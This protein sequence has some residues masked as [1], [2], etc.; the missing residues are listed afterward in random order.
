[1]P[2][3]YLAQPQARRITT[4][5]GV[6]A[7]FAFV[8]ADATGYPTVL[9]VAIAHLGGAQY[10]ALGSAIGGILAVVSVPLLAFLAAR[11]PHT[12]PTL[13]GCGLLIQVAAVVVRGIA[14]NIWVLLGAG[15]F[16]SL[17]TAVSYVIGLPLVRDMFPAAR[18][19]LLLGLVGTASSIGQIAGPVSVGRIIDWW[20]WRQ[21]SWF[22]APLLAI[23]AVLVLAGA[24]I[25][26][27][28]GAQIAE[29]RRFDA[30]GAF[31]M[32]ALVTLLILPLSLGHSS[33][34]YGGLRSYLLF[35]G[36][37]LGVVGF[38]MVVR[39]KKESAFISSEVFKD[40]NTLALTIQTFLS[41]GSSFTVLAF[42]PLY[43]LY[44]MHGSGFQSG[45]A[46]A[47]FAV[48]GLFLAPA[49]GRWIGRTGSAAGV[50]YASTA[51]KVVVMAGLGIMILKAPSHINIWVIYTAMLLAGFYNAG[52]TVTVQTA[53]QLM[54]S[55]RMRAQGTASVSVQVTLGPIIGAAGFGGIVLA[56]GPQKGVAI[57]LL[58][59]A[60]AALLALV[61]V[62]F[63][64]PL[65]GADA[66]EA[67]DADGDL[68]MAAAPP[69]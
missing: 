37:A 43:V 38:A 51:F 53:P 10:Y 21:V 63:F 35:A 4:L 68:Q 33:I 55:P 64:R 11:N 18:A 41:T 36:A 23:S 1:M 16:L 12:R 69:H 25:T 26:K 60:G 8:I 45:M 44:V 27:A 20:G 13:M 65:V 47:L 50:I 24:R 66:E 39:K 19:S 22:I 14:P 67:A 40:R 52:G 34:P 17:G 28:E 61:P 54:L 3:P 59:A 7:A 15:V 32:T 57:A 62:S 49:L 56:H 5:I 31:L 42:V 46:S 2:H 48:P 6:Y 58:A 9:P 29:S 30:I